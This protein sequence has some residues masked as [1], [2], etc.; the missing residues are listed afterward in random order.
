[1]RETPYIDKKE[2][3]IFQKRIKGIKPSVLRSIL[4]GRDDV[5]WWRSLRIRAAWRKLLGKFRPESHD[6]IRNQ[7]CT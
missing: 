3:L 4:D 5:G 6:A 7:Y 1:M 2:R